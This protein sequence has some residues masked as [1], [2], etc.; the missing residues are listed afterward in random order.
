MI[1]FMVNFLEIFGT[2]FN[3]GDMQHELSPVT[4]S[5]YDY[6]H[7]FSILEVLGKGLDPDRMMTNSLS[8]SE[9][10]TPTCESS[11]LFEVLRLSLCPKDMQIEIPAV[12]PEHFVFYGPG[13]HHRLTCREKIRLQNY[14]DENHPEIVLSVE[15]QLNV[16]TLEIRASSSYYKI[17][18]GKIDVYEVD[19]AANRENGNTGITQKY[20]KVQKLGQTLTAP[21]TRD[22][23]GFVST[24]WPIAFS[25]DLRSL[26]VNGRRVAQ[27][28]D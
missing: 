16:V 9:P 3:P 23:E 22:K 4:P 13:S 11:H 7:S 24:I 15:K 10:L 20:I 6:T 1:A 19:T 14:Q 28:V 18:W 27:F 21:Y 2:K 8:D 5:L 12:S 26:Y 17:N 25:T